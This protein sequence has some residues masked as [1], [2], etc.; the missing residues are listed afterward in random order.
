[1]SSLLNPKHEMFAQGLARGQS[2][3]EAYIAAGFKPNSGNACTLKAKESIIK[4][5]SAILSDREKIQ[6]LATQRAVTE[7]AID[8]KW[9][10]T[11]L[12]TN[13]E[14]AMQNEPVLD[15]EGKPTGDYR[16]EGSVANRALELVGK[17][18]GMFIDRH[19]V[20]RPGEF[21]DM[22]PAQLR[23]FITEESAEL[24]LGNETVN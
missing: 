14:R 23:S 2:A 8:K 13:V 18:L 7:L 15:S 20:G 4:R 11:R 19:E 12:V 24:G 17:E 9:V 21:E 6:E 22:T 16:Y 10:L 5:V 3:V 1:M